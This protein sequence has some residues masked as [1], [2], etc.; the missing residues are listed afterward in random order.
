MTSNKN[1]TYNSTSFIP[2]DMLY[3]F[4]NGCPGI[5]YLIRENRACVV[6]DSFKATNMLI[7]FQSGDKT[8]W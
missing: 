4:G 3:R 2:I 8:I 1:I 7:L 6:R 5:R